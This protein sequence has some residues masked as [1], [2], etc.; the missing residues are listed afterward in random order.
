[1][2]AGRRVPAIV[3][4]VP[5]GG[6]VSGVDIL[7]EAPVSTAPAAVPVLATASRPGTT[8]TA[9]IRGRVSD[10]SGQPLAGVSV[11]PTPGAA[12]AGAIT[13]LEG[14]YVLS[15][16]P[17]GAFG[18]TGSKS[19]YMSS[20]YAGDSQ[21]PALPVTLKDGQEVDGID[22]V[23]SRTSTIAGTVVDE[24]GEP[25]EGAS[26]QLLRV[27]LSGRGPV[28]AAPQVVSEFGLRS[29]DDRGYFRLWGVTPGVYVALATVPPELG[30]RDRLRLAYAPMYYPRG[31]HVG[32]A[33]TLQVS[34]GQDIAGLVINM[35]RV[36]VARVA[37][38]ALNSE[39][40][41]L[42]G[43]V[44]LSSAPASGIGQQPRQMAAGANGEFAFTNVPP[45]EY[46]VHTATAAG[47][48]GS[49]FAFESVTVTDR[50]PLPVTLRASPGSTVSG[51]LVLEGPSGAVM[52]DYAANV[53]PIDAVV[54]SAPSS[55]KS[56]GAFSTG[57]TFRFTG[58]AGSARILF[59]TPDEKWF[60]KSVVIDGAD[61]TDRPFD[62]GLNGRAYEAEVLF[63]P[64]VASVA[65]RVTDERGVAVQQYAVI[66]FGADRDKWFNGSRWLKMGRAGSDGTF[67][68]TGL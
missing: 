50:D 19:G 10:T 51:R 52:W 11:R 34:A 54:L 1:M 27:S 46:V 26:V 60:L 20:R 44:R 6:E 38:V 15:G 49:E 14:R 40:L 7:I 31:A 8:S 65:G 23:M 48:S 28:A 21:L 58:V 37:G 66:L 39:G 64:N 53:V 29:T 5:A 3:V 12:Q 2:F 45:G 62:F 43:T 47:P 67:R 59:S 25:L 57:V 9:R 4:D 55:S 35:S 16:L 13:D 33:T 56:S 42:T 61:V 41:P 36:A 63:S 18:V 22:L 68:L 17:A 32:S 30:D 24:A